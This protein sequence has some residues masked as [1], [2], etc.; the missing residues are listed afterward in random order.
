[1]PDE[2][3][4]PPEQTDPPPP[5]PP[6]GWDTGSPSHT[7]FDPLLDALVVISRLNGNP[8]VATALSSGLPLVEHRLTT[9]LLPRAAERA[10]LSARLL[11]RELA[12]IP[13]QVLP[14]IILLRQSRAAVL[15]STDSAAGTA[16]ISRY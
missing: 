16:R 5:P 10:G 1:M 15:V 11:R 14:A 7:F 3:P 9:D 6:V 8:Q 4:P 13:S 12:E 2:T